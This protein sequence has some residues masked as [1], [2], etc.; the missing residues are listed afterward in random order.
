[1][2]APPSTPATGAVTSDTA[3]MPL[4]PIQADGSDV[5]R[6]IAE[7]S[8]LSLNDSIYATKNYKRKWVS[9]SKRTSAAMP[10]RRVPLMSFS[11]PFAVLE[12]DKATGSPRNKTT[13]EKLITNYQ[14]E[15]IAKFVKEKV[16]EGECNVNTLVKKVADK[17][18]QLRRS[19]NSRQSPS[20]PW[21]TWTRNLWRLQSQPTKS[22]NRLLRLPKPANQ[23]PAI[24]KW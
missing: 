13:Q 23:A 6:K 7:S 15:V 24:L 8:N 22:R 5:L 9:A 12:E 17:L 11:N 14:D 1:M 10:A 16:A 2:K 18:L 4:E 19:L 20:Q 3:V 21:K